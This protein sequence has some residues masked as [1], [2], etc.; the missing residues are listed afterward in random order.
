M[1]AKLL[2]FAIGLSFYGA[3][4]C[5]Q[6]GS[7][8]FNT[9]RNDLLR[10]YTDHRESILNRYNE[11][12]KGVWK[13][14]QGFRDTVSN[15]APKPLEQPKL[16]RSNPAEGSINL[17]PKFEPTIG[18]NKN[19]PITPPLTPTS[20]TSRTFPIHFYGLSLNLPEINGITL[21]TSSD[22]QQI[23]SYWEKLLKSDAGCDFLSGIEAA[24]STHGFN[25]WLKLDLLRH[26]LNQVL[27]DMNAGTR[28]IATHYLL[29]RLGYDVRLGITS[30]KQWVLLVA[31]QQT[32]YGRTFIRLHNKKFYVYYDVPTGQEESSPIISTC[33]IPESVYPGKEINLAFSH[34]LTLPQQSMHEFSISDGRL[35]IKGTISEPLI[36]MLV[37]YPQMPIPSYA[38]SILQADVREQIIL[39]LKQQTL[40]LNELDAVNA[41]LSF[42]QHAFQYATDGQQFGYEKPFFFEELL[43]YPQC[44][45]EDRAVFYTYLLKNVLGL[46]SHLLKF[47]GHESVAVCLS[48]PINGD[49]YIHQGKHYYISDPTYI[50]AQTGMCMSVYQHEQP[51][52]EL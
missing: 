26:A 7:D 21:F 23:S 12:L 18:I 34:P 3:T 9:F 36:K 8:S 29:T 37:H 48:Q 45:C 40:G 10:R 19:P 38:S 32:V 6:Q 35:S 28:I 13:E 39:Q 11:Y 24:T 31:F 46:D 20:P 51:E 47:P 17:A 49:G 2:G 15:I 41:L 14:Y 27:K 16:S 33:E 52:I 43:Y 42:V 44:D 1:N 25:D 5:A 22:R 4:L 30:S 50:G